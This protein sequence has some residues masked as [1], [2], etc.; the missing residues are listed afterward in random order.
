MTPAD[1]AEL[2]RAYYWRRD[3]EMETT[4]WALSAVINFCG[5]LKRGHQM[6]PDKL[7]GRPIGD[8]G[9]WAREQNEEEDEG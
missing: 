4:A 9:Q 1:T 6:K 3:R 8:F 2:V 5:H 7:L